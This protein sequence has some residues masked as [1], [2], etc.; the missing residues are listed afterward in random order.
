MSTSAPAAQRDTLLTLLFPADVE[1]VVID[2]LLA[3][4]E[5]ANGFTCA[6]VDGHGAAL[7]PRDA[8]ERVRGR[9]RRFQVQIALAQTQAEA[10]IAHFRTELANPDVAYWTVPLTSFGRLS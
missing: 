7:Q 8:A 5:W 1:D 9:S 4:P 3:H 10:L 2:H 6:Q